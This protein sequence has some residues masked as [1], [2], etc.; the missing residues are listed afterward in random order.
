MFY[1]FGFMGIFW[2]IAWQKYAGSSPEEDTRISK[3]EQ[4]YIVDQ[5][6]TRVG[7]LPSHLGHF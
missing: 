6:V 7:A 5:T 4:S 1:I 2:F 3:E